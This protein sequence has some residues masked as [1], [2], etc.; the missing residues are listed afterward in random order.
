MASRHPRNHVNSEERYAYYLNA[1]QS[2]FAKHNITLTEVQLLDLIPE[3][4]KQ[5]ETNDAHSKT[6]DLLHG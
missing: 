5:G 2:G 1:F 4:L 3:H 6:D